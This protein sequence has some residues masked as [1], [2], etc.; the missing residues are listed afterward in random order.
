MKS[1]EVLKAALERMDSG[2]KWCKGNNHIADK[3][4]TY[5]AITDVDVN[6]AAR[7][8]ICKAIGGWKIACWNDS[9]SDF[10]VIEKGFER[11]IS[12]AIAEG[13]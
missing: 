11:A 6:S 2:R 13:D 4:C 7:E 10:S 8:F 12:L 3:C 9:A 5:G 1:S